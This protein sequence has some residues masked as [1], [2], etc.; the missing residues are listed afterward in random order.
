MGNGAHALLRTLLAPFSAAYGTAIRARN[1]RYDC[2]P[3]ASRRVDIPV[4]SIGNITVG[5]TGKTP[6]V[7]DIVRRLRGLG[8]RPAILTR[9]YKAAPGAE[10]DEV[11]EFR[12]ALPDT[13]VVVNPDRIAGA[14]IAILQHRSDCVVLDDGF[15]HRRLRRDLDIVLI[16]ALNPWGY[17]RVLPAGRLREP[18]SGLGRAHVIIITR[19]NQVDEHAVATIEERI[20]QL[21]PRAVCV[22]SE[23]RAA[24]VRGPDGG[25]TALD[26]MPSGLVLPVCGIGNP[27]TFVRLLT[28]SGTQSARPLTFSDH[29]RYDPRDVE[30]IAQRA[31]DVG[32]VAVVTTRKDWVKLA[33]LWTR[34]DAPPLLRLDV[35]VR[36]LDTGAALS[37][38]LG[39]LTAS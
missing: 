19:T 11:L 30:R 5:G 8:R 17:E 14:Q 13:P 29:H 34:T 15:Q 26:A 27:A 20:S 16:D 36:V 24:G 18:L 1:W 39:R 23:V 12:T 3:S 32:A 21:A 7:I 33:R 38:L 25:A 2:F 28:D 37:A 9:G 4:V 31:R 10:A 35:D 6:M 22:R